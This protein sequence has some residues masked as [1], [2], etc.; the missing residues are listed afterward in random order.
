MRL[1]LNHGRSRA[2]GLPVWMVSPARPDRTQG[3]GS[4]NSL[5]PAWL[6]ELDFDLLSLAVQGLWTWTE[7]HQQPSWVALLQTADGGTSQSP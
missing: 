3:G 1:A 4:R 2:G 6:L 7:S 5:L